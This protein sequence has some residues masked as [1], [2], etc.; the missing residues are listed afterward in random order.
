M[1]DKGQVGGLM[2]FVVFF[3]IISLLYIAFS[4]VFGVLVE[5]DNWL[6]SMLPYSQ[7]HH[8]ASNSIYSGWTVYPVIA[9]IAGILAFIANAL[10]DKSGRVY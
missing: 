8:D 1:D 10:R 4:K 6:M 3:F 5:T 2:E 7:A 9:L